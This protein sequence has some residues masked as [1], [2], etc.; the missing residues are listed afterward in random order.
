MKVTDEM[1]EAG[2]KAAN[3]EAF[4]QRWPQI[5]HADDW[6]D[7][8]EQER[9]GWLHVARACLTAALTETG[10]DECPKD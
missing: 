7:I 9:S 6:G 5:G 4:R 3:L 8:T 2:A 1:V 10:D